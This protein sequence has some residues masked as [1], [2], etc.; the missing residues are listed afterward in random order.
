MFTFIK[1][2]KVVTV[3]LLTVSIGLFSGCV[4]DDAASTDSSI[5]STTNPMTTLTIETPSTS[6][7]T[8]ETTAVSTTEA[9]VIE[10][11]ALTEEQ[12]TTEIASVPTADPAN[13]ETPIIDAPEETTEK[14]NIV[15]AYVGPADPATGLSWD[16]VSPIIYTYTDGTTGTTPIE[17][18]TYESIPGVTTTY[19]VYS[20]TV[21]DYYS[22]DAITCYL[23]GRIAGDGSNGTC[24]R[25][26]AG[27][28]HI[29]NNCG[30]TVPTGV[31][32][33]CDAE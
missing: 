9:T 17:G 21:D 33:T 27:S 16:G 31:C 26:L 4:S 15:G 3:L 18:A 23:C 24:V 12:S 32:H 11:V 6:I 2:H 28:E 8:T 25:W 7:T 20:S 14:T 29:C 30:S 1:K 10:T 13:T 5:F 19:K 22:N